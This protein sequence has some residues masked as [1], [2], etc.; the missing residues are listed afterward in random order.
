[1]NAEEVAPRAETK[2]S[3]DKIF[4]IPDLENRKTKIVCTIG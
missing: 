1:M 2:I 4:N 3:F